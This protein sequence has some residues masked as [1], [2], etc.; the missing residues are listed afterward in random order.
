LIAT[1]FLGLQY[2]RGIWLEKNKDLAEQYILKSQREKITFLKE[3]VNKNDLLAQYYLGYLYSKSIV[4]EQKQQ[5]A[6]L[7][8]SATLGCPSAQCDLGY[9]NDHSVNKSNAKSVEWYRRSTRQKHS[10]AEY[11]LV[12]MYECGRYLDKDFVEAFDLLSS[13]SQSGILSC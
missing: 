12:Q 11:H 4:I 2:Y 8:K 3:G 5:K 7:I 9:A 6:M 10:V 13:I 1:F